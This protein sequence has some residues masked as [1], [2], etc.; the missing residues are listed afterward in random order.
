L[1][2]AAIQ[3]TAAMKIIARTKWNHTRVHVSPGERYSLRADGK[4]RDFFISCDANG[5]LTE[6]VP[7][8]TR[9]LMRRYE[10]KRRAPAE[11]WFCLMG[12]LAEDDTRSFR[13][14]AGRD[15]SPTEAG[16]LLCFANDVPF[17]Y[18]NN[19]GSI[20]LTIQRL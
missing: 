19:F 4:W 7:A 12:A 9:G 15:W 6:R 17:A 5:Y 16:E 11:P 10:S 13:I 18:W 8:L 3:L 1:R 20:E 14:G 2:I